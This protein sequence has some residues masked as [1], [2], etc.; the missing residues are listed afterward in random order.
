MAVRAVARD[1][2]AGHARVHAR[3]VV[4]NQ[5]S[6]LVRR[7]RARE[8]FRVRH[9]P[10][11]DE[12]SRNRDLAERSRRDVLDDERAHL[13]VRPAE[14]A[15]RRGVH[16]AFDLRVLGHALRHDVRRAELVAAVH[17][18]DFRR[19]ARDEV[20]LLAC[21]IA[22][23]DH[24]DVLALVEGGVAGRA[25]AH[26]VPAVKFLFAGN[27]RQ[28]RR[29]ARR[30]DDR[31]RLIDFAGARLQLLH[32]AGKIDR[33]DQIDLEARAEFFRLLADVPGQR[34]T[35]HAVGKARKIF[36]DG[37]RRDLSAGQRTFENERGK[38]RARGVN[39][40]RRARAAAPENDDVFH[41]RKDCGAPA[42]FQRKF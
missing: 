6:F 18:V 40:G 12:D 34:E 32:D 7:Q 39:S 22:A 3:I 2:H 20:R 37:G 30:D 14:N 38:S 23:A 28:P 33:L 25:G 5:R 8:K 26:A 19:E 35:V 42:F 1:E 36:D 31:L 13:A 21:G 4:G 41:A 11:R 24:G 27:A 15:L 10:D 17:D 29:R 16:H 9:V